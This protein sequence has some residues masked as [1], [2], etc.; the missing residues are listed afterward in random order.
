MLKII[1]TTIKIS[2]GDN[3]AILFSC[4]DKQGNPYTFTQGET[5]QFRVFQKNGYDDEAILS[6]ECEV[7][8][9]TEVVEI[10]LTS[11]D[12]TI[13][14]PINAPKIYWYEISINETNT[15]IGY[16]NDPALFILLPAREDS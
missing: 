15:V 3:A 10:E 11:D 14:N 2:R 16:E 13:G 1:G 9:D 6:K 7:E 12:T 5:I 4:N 8:E